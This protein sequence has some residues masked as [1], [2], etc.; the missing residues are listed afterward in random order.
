MAIADPGVQNYRA[1]TNLRDL[2]LLRDCEGKYAAFVRGLR[3]GVSE[4]R[5][6]LSEKMDRVFPNDT[7]LIIRVEKPKK[8]R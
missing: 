8:I 4:D 6:E 5:S 2:G 3:V 7:R 1:Y